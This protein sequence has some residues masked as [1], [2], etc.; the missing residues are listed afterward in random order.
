MSEC[1]TICPRDTVCINYDRA[2]L[3]RS[4]DSWVVNWRFAV[5]LFTNCYR[6]I[7]CR[8]HNNRWGRGSQRSFGVI[9]IRIRLPWTPLDFLWRKEYSSR[10]RFEPRLFFRVMFTNKPQNRKAVS[11]VLLNNPDLDWIIF[12]VS[13]R[14]WKGC[15]FLPRTQVHAT[16]SNTFSYLRR[17]LQLL[18]ACVKWDLIVTQE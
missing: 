9:W 12:S 8:S 4:L 3:Q 11:S 13:E 17:K 10:R 16:F 5:A 2:S 15:V 7:V 14:V 1:H 18:L 6:N